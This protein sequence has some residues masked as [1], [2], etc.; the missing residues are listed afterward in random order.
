MCKNMISVPNPFY[1]R[2]GYGFSQGVPVELSGH[3]LP[4][5]QYITVPCGKC[6]ECRSTYYNSILQRGICE[7]LSSYVYFVT[8]TYD[9]EHIP[10][11]DLDGERILYADYRHIQ[12]MVKR[13]RNANVLDREFR[14]LCVN[15]YGDKFS[16]PHFHLLV[17]VGKRPSDSDNTPYEIEKLL[18]DNL[19]KFFAIN[20]GTRKNPRYQT[21]FTYAEKI[22]S[23]GLRSNYWVKFV[24]K[25][26]LDYLDNDEDVYI[27]TLSYLIGY[28]NTPTRLDKFVENFLVSHSYDTILCKKLKS[29]L[30]NKVRYSKGYGNG[31][32]D[33]MKHYLPRINCRCSSNIVTYSEL[34]QNLPCDYYEFQQNYPDFYESLLEW[35]ELDKYSRYD[36]LQDCVKSFSV[37]DFFLH[38][39]AVKYLNKELS[40][41]FY[42]LY[43]PPL[44]ATI[45]N[46]FNLHT[47][48]RY[49]LQHV[50]TSSSDDSP[51]FWFLRSGVEKGLRDKVAY[52]T[53]PI[54]SRV[55]YSCLCKYYRDR[56][57]TFDDWQRLFDGCRV[58][59]YDAWIKQFSSS[60]NTHKSDLAQSNLL[61]NAESSQIILQKQKK[62]L[63]LRNRSSNGVHFT[64]FVH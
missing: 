34:V 50:S 44:E 26:K 18:H 28:V 42:N 57:C 23:L 52:F 59:D 58:N 9:D 63:H 38:C 31:F 48:Y 25:S 10:F 61:R 3:L 53:F 43:R 24:E 36:N 20:I 14:Y 13:F 64:L 45:S 15:E 60:Y 17:F 40:S 5:D 22:T 55:G 33:G 2:K 29:I 27:R 19:G 49:E 37:D 35:I 51:L 54:K 11:I 4:K 47:N 12:N 30:S 41:H 1:H 8:L 39:L 46:F 56:V 21:L 6:S 32:V 16:R 62:S 7:A